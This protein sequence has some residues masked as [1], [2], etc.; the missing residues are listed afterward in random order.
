MR[1]LT[2]FL[3]SILVFTGCVQS[4]KTFDGTFEGNADSNGLPPGWMKWG[5]GYKIYLDE[6]VHHNGHQSLCITPTGERKTDAY[7]VGVAG[8]PVNFSGKEITLTGYLKL[9]NVQNG[10]AGLIIR[11]DGKDGTLATDSMDEKNI[12]G[13]VDWEAYRITLP[14]PADAKMIYVGAISSGTGRLW[15]D[16]LEVTVDNKP[17]QQAPPAVVYKADSDTAFDKGSGIH[18][19][20]LTTV[21]VHDLEVLGKTWGFLKYYHPAIAAGNY[22]WDYELF[23]ILPSVL[24]AR[25]PAER[26]DVLLKW[27]NQLPLPAN[28]KREQTDSSGV[29]MQPDLGWI[30]DETELGKALPAALKQVKDFNRNAEH[31]YIET[32]DGNSPLFKHEGSY[33]S[34]FYPDAGFRLLSLFR[35]WNAIQYYFPYKY[36]ITE[37]WNNKLAEYIPVFATARDTTAYQTGLLRLIASIHDS[38][39]ILYGPNWVVQNIYKA[40]NLPLRMRFINDKPVVVK[41][42]NDTTGLRKGDVIV[43]I[44]GEPVADVVKRLLPATS[45]SNYAVQLRRIESKLFLTNDSMLQVTFERAGATQ[46]L[47][48][49]TLPSAKAYLKHDEPGNSWRLI[50]SDIGYVHSGIFNKIQMEMM[51]AS[52]KHTKGMVIDVRC[53]PSDDVTALVEYVLP[54]PHPFVKFTA[55]SREHPGLFVFGPPDI[56]GRD[57]QD[58]YKGKVIILVNESTQSRAEFVTMALR[59]APKAVILGSTTAGA[60]GTVAVLKL[61]G[62]LE[63]MFTG[64]GVYYPDGR[65]TQRIGIIPDIVMEPTVKGIRENKDEI[66]EK[67]LSLIRE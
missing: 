54:S 11:I 66:L 8:I 38:H 67:A 3:F 51:A 22:N 46:T 47:A 35:Y 10:S 18:I 61:P 31:Y 64:I 21:Q 6:Q 58:Y 33:S 48:V 60:D 39:A 53:Y 59:L 2:F 26:N 55:V 20:T 63:C 14:L 1:I 37:G 40:N 34:M 30:T 62:G 5:T 49:T 15:A 16:D 19:T 44:N 4:K 45:G 57:N 32:K 23:R 25:N 13:T 29:K 65:E 24:N 27:V 9:E 41:V 17:W 42:E 56:A 43:A 7:G 36:L 12:H 28:N 50:G 52:F